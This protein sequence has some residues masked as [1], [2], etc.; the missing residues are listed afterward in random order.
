VWKA[1]GERLAGFYP[2]Q[3][4]QA[5][6]WLGWSSDNR[7][8]TLG[9]GRLTAWEVP[10]ARVAF[11]IDGGYAAPVELAPGS[12]WLAVA[13]G[14][15]VDLIETASGRCLGR[16]RAGGVSGVVRDVVLSGDGQRLAVVFPGAADPKLGQFTAALWDLTRGRADLLPFGR[17]PYSTVHWIGSDL[18]VTLTDGSVLYDLALGRAIAG[19]AFPTSQWRWGGPLFVRAPDG[20]V[21]YRRDQHPKA[22]RGTSTGG[23]WWAVSDDDFRGGLRALPDP[24]RQ[25]V[26]T[27]SSPVRVEVDLGAP[28]RSQPYAEQLAGLLQKQGFSIGPGGWSFRLTHEVIGTGKFLSLGSRE[29]PEQQ[30]PAV[31]FT[32]QLLDAEGKRAWMKQTYSHFAGPASR[33]FTGA[34]TE[35]V[36]GIH[37][38][39]MQ[40]TYYNFGPLGMR[41][42][43]ALE[44]LEGQA[45]H[46]AIPGDLPQ[47]LLKGAGSYC[48]LPVLL[49]PV[50][51]WSTM[52]EPPGKKQ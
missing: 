28:A 20:R 24:N 26:W 32:W 43:I 18:L 21:W 39:E 40:T 14:D 5:V 7:L 17:D 2:Y 22:R 6:E 4:G 29:G 42:A 35:K 48:E 16:C 37:G 50:P 52:P 36:K 3:S 30:I 38:F 46:A 31:R 10:S 51:H 12:A 1:T 13:G 41:A 19:Y 15:R 45:Q 23:V 47:A 9:G 44:I 33:Y 8:L 27:R 49:K 34:T 25:W 11:E